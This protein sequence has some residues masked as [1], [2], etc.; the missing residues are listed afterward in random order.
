[1]YVLEPLACILSSF[2]FFYLSSSTFIHVFRSFFFC[3]SFFGSIFVIMQA[4]PK[5][6]NAT[7]NVWQLYLYIFDNLF[8][9][10]SEKYWQM[11]KLFIFSWVFS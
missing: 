5:Q 2:L 3:S 7:T 6:L 4:L 9:M 10:Q 1:V 8:L 11:Q